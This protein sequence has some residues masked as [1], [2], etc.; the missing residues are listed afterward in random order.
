MSDA[1]S[2]RDPVLVFD[3]LTVSYRN[4]TKI[5]VLNEFSLELKTGEFLAVVGPSG[6][7]KSTLLY[8]TAGF[9]KPDNG[10]IRL[11]GRL[12]LEPS[13]QIGFVSQRY[14]LFPWLTV[15]DNIGFG[16]RSQEQN[17]LKTRQTVDHLLEVIGLRAQRAYY[18][19]QLSG[20]MQQR[21]A[22]ARAMAPNPVVLLL[23]EPFS[24]LDSHNRQK[25]RDLL[26][27]LWTDRGTTVLF[28]THDIE[29][30]LLLGDNV[31]MLEADAAQAHTLR[32][33]FP[34]PRLHTLLR[35]EAFRSL[36]NSI[37]RQYG[38]FLETPPHV[39]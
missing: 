16:L 11:K 12:I 32:V 2:P 30:A 17:N 19:E 8:A 5:P 36:L 21:V 39:K 1:P 29:E 31:L 9:I 28:V 4:G 23:D 33:P 7:G 37:S 34:R 13:L 22:L 38:A 6:C 26:L 25:M 20:G 15:E 18:P 3:R 35:D 24:A 10:S 27:H 14:A